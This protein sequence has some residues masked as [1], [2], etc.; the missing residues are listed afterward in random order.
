MDDA[1]KK[2]QL[3]LAIQESRGQI[4]SNV[5]GIKHDLSFG[6]RFRQSV[7]QKPAAWYAGAALL[8]LMLA[9]IPRMGRK[10][11]V[12]RTVSSDVKKGGMA[13][14]ALAVTKFAV[15]FAKPTILAWMRTR[16]RQHAPVRPPRVR[17]TPVVRHR[18]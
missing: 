8:G 18:P 10:I 15:D 2:Q 9:L 7:K 4:A 17:P 16:M 13:A 11:V 6:R 5:A 3:R 14:M 12:T 1:A